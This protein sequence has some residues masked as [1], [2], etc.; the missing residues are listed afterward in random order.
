MGRVGKPTANSSLQFSHSSMRVFLL[1][2]TGNV[3]RLVLSELVKSN[4]QVLAVVRSL[5]RIPED[6]KHHRDVQY[7]VKNVLNMK[8]EEL[9]DALRDCESCVI[10]LGHRISVRGIWGPPYRLVRDAVQKIH[11]ASEILHAEKKSGA[12]L[13]LVILSTVG[14]T[15]PDGS[16]ANFRGM[17]EKAFVWIVSSLVPPWSDSMLTA[18]YLH[19]TIGR[20]DKSLEWVAVRPDSLVDGQRCQYALSQDLR[21]GLFN[22]G[23][24]RKTNLVHFI[25][26]LL[27]DDDLWNSWKGKMPVILDE[28]T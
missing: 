12:R 24:T 16:E 13:K 25:V 15:N 7:V 1:G 23:E 2:A 5:D 6:L 10:C 27:M 9:A 20:V 3:G 19:N 14:V 8:N 4:L 28:Q 18:Q 26:S 17:F 22:P 11:S 21:N